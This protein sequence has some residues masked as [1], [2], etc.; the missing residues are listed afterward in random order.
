M[1]RSLR[2]SI[3]AQVVCNELVASQGFEPQ[4]AES[5]SAVLPLN[6]E[7]M[8]AGTARN[9][10]L[11]KLRLRAKPTRSTGQS[12]EVGRPRVNERNGPKLS[13]TPADQAVKRQ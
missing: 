10:A 7:A 5:E 8:S 11:P 2:G 6:D 9:V 1:T 12:Y 13:S 4:Y 3:S